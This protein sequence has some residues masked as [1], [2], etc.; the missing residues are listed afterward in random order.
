MSQ[1]SRPKWI[2]FWYIIQFLFKAL[3]RERSFEVTWRNWAV[4]R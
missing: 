2:G 4:M 3:E 1:N